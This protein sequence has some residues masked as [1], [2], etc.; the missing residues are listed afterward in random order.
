MGLTK[1]RLYKPERR[2]AR[3]KGVLEKH[4][5]IGLPTAN[6]FEIAS[7]VASLCEQAGFEVGR[8]GDYD[9]LKD[10]YTVIGKSLV[11]GKAQE[12]KIQGGEVAFLIKV[13]RGLNGGPMVP[14]MQKR[15]QR[16]VGLRG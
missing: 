15:S 10:E 1:R 11:T 14:E 2:P 12:I 7:A 3:K 16:L 6:A 5:P 4:A 13:G 9:S 8:G